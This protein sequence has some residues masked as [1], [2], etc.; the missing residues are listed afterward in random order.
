MNLAE[1][2]TSFQGWL[3]ET[4]LGRVIVYEFAKFNLSV[5]V[6]LQMYNSGEILDRRTVNNLNLVFMKVES[7]VSQI[8]ID[9]ALSSE[10]EV[11][12]SGLRLELECAYLSADEEMTRAEFA[13]QVVAYFLQE[14]MPSIDDYVESLTDCR[15]HEEIGLV[16]DDNFLVDISNSS[17]FILKKHGLVVSEDIMVYPHQFLRRCYSSNFVDILEILNKYKLGGKLVKIRIDPMRS[18]VH[19]N[20]YRN[21]FEKDYWHGPRFSPA[22]LNSR[23]SEEQ[24]TVHFSDA[25]AYSSYP[26]SATIFRTYLMEKNLRQ[27][28]IEEYTP[29]SSTDDSARLPGFG[30]K[31][32]IQKFGHFVFD[33]NQQAITHIDGAV[34]VFRTDEYDGIYRSILAGQDA[35][36]KI[37]S[38]HK[39][40]LVE[41]VL[42]LC[43]AQS[44][45]FEFFRY[46]PHLAEYFGVPG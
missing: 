28:M 12:N 5:G 45:M 38:R 33:Q 7:L 1:L 39:L 42:D 41:G 11:E 10:V 13:S 18:R 14:L 8:D 17:N 30:R 32:C 27:F 15:L 16:R 9:V 40:F 23:D 20:Y 3:D 36:S 44:L 6:G 37:G 19:P 4:Q 29:I 43:D 34:R 46:N 22:V 35:G 31:Y 26:V 24:V 21:Y 2:R 25:T